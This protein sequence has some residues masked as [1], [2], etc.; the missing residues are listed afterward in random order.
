MNEDEL[1]IINFSNQ[2]TISILLK[3]K[4][5]FPLHRNIKDYSKIAKVEYQNFFSL[6]CASKLTT[7]NR[8][9]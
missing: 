3:R 1:I 4:F 6:P 7:I 5:F 8:K 2:I 9:D